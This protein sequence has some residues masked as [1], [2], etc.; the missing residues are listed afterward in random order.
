MG[1]H[2]SVSDHVVE[3]TLSRA[4]NVTDTTHIRRHLAALCASEERSG[5]PVELVHFEVFILCTAGQGRHVVDSVE[6]ELR[7]G[8]ALWIRP[9]QT[10][11]WSERHSHFEATVAVFESVRIPDL[12]LFETAIASNT[13]V[14]LDDDA[15]LL[16][17]QMDWMA[18]DLEAT[19]DEATAAAVVG[20]IL[21]L[22]ARRSID[23]TSPRSARHDIADAFARS[24]AEHPTERSVAWHARNIGSSTRT[25]SRATAEALGQ[26]PKELLDTHLVVE[27]QRRLAWSGDD[28]ATI[29]RSLDFSDASN[30]TKFFRRRTD[31]S[32]SEFRERFRSASTS[33][34]MPRPD[35]ADTDVEPGGSGR[36][37]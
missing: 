25:V 26:R 2:V 13:M 20:V 24:V 8:T 32:P 30:F 31:S 28:V 12:P 29:A 27:A 33:A 9:G 6:H 37:V 11:Q 10:Q 15:E 16:R 3:M 17:Q 21:R 5:W 23:D 36:G 7:P 18:A 4:V 14:M 1:V 35:P 34:Q 22:F 19:Q